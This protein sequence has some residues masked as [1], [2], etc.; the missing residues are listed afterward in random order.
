M[1]KTV[2][3]INPKELNGNQRI[4]YR[5][6]KYAANDIIGSLENGLEDEPEDSQFYADY[7]ATL[8]D[9]EG[10]V[11]QIE[12]AAMHGT[13][14]VGFSGGSAIKEMRFAGGEFIR[15]VIEQL[16]SDMGY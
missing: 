1:T 15:R 3:R 13:Y 5:N 10:L 12:F 11:N 9:H 4:A 7:K 16:V 8:A 14:D 2:S 6:C